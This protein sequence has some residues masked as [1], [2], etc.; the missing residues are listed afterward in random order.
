MHKKKKH[1]T[2]AVPEPDRLALVKAAAWAWHQHSSSPKNKQA[3]APPPEFPLDSP[4]RRSSNCRPSRY[5]LESL[6]LSKSNSPDHL[7]PEKKAPI[8][9]LDFYEIER[10]TRELERLAATVTEKREKVHG[11]KVVQMRKGTTGGGCLFGRHAVMIC[12]SPDTAAET[13]ALN[14]RPTS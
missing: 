7:V 6:T 9:L 11:K 12:G 8:T 3:P 1:T 2:A 4:Q 10:I 5:R 13:E 14:C